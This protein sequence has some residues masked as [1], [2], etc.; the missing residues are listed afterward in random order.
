MKTIVTSLLLLLISGVLATAQTEKGRWN[1]GVSVGNFS[2][3]DNK[4]A[5]TKT[6]TGNLSPSVG[7]FVANNL[8][9]GTGVPLSLSTS[10]QGNNPYVSKYASTSVGLSPF[11]R[12]FFGAAKLKPYVGLSYSH[13]FV[14]NTYNSSAFSTDFSSDGYSIALVPTLGVAYFINQTIAIY[15][16]LNYNILSSKIGYLS[17]ANNNPTVTDIKSDSRSASLSIGFQIFFGK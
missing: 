14:R 10:K 4:N 5:D 16:G 7:Y 6:F 11:V 17:F 12:Y 9:I 8:L 2:Y 3:Q 13:S 1:V 15:A